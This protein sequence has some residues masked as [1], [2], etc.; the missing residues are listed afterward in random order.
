MISSVVGALSS[1]VAHGHQVM[2]AFPLPP[3][4]PSAVKRELLSGRIHSV[5]SSAGLYLARFCCQSRIGVGGG[6][7]HRL[8]PSLA[9]SVLGAGPNATG[10]STP[11]FGEFNARRSGARGDGLD[12]GCCRHVRIPEGK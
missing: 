3:H 10:S 9:T 1:I 7:E 5:Q 6:S 11:G 12:P 4:S 8:C 2:A